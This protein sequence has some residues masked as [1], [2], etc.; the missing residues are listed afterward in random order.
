MKFMKLICNY[1]IM[2]TLQ[3]LTIVYGAE[4]CC[5]NTFIHPDSMIHGAYMRP[6]WGRQDSGG[7]HV[8]PMILAVSYVNTLKTE[9]RHDTNFVEMRCCSATEDD[10]VGFMTTSFQYI[11][12]CGSSGNGLCQT[13]P[14]SKVHGANMGPIWGRQ[15]GPMLAP[16]T[17][18][19][20]KLH[21]SSILN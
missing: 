8:G 2:E 10:K 14:D 19:S 7:P 1:D 3:L 21:W 6:T 13:N 18:L 12:D 20:G 4:S 17:L 15:V 9:S 16:W 5:E 11:V